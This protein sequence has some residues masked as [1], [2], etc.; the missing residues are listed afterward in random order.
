M[1]A[2]DSAVSDDRLMAALMTPGGRGAVATVQFLGDCRVIDEAGSVLF[3]AANGK[4]L[5]EQAVGRIVFGG[6]GTCTPEDVVVCRVDARQLEIHCHGGDSASRRVLDDL[7]RVGCS[8]VGWEELSRHTLGPFAAECL[9]ALS[10]ATTQ[11][12]A[13][14]LLRQHSGLLRAAI[15]NIEPMASGDGRQPDQFSDDERAGATQRFDELLCWA[16]FGLHLTQP[17]R[18]VL[19][20]RPNV[21]KSSLSNALVGYSRSIVH[22]TPGTTR[23][24]VTVET[25]LDGWPIRFSDTAGIRDAGE[26]IE[27][28]GIER[29]RDELQQAD[30]RVVLVDVSEPPHADDRTLIDGWPDAIRVAHKCDLDDVWAGSLPAGCLHVSSVTGEGVDDLAGEIVSRLVPKVPAK[31]VAVPITA[32]QVST[33]EKARR[34]LEADDVSGFRRSIGECLFCEESFEDA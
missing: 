3:R 5:V 19:A 34:A 20:G 4:P 17:Y 25:A 8:I 23:D 1:C 28:A 2:G 31:R 33:L 18:V 6:W 30:C 29:A 16:N 11:R 12:T 22:G 13:D 7:E 10:S 9:E 24:V 27:S 14:F 21:G 26:P 32:R 15:E